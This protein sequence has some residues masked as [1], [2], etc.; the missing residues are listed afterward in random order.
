MSV[1]KNEGLEF[2]NVNFTYKPYTP[3]IQVLPQFKG[4]YGGDFRDARGLICNGDFS[5]A[6]VGN[7][8]K[9]YEVMNKNY[10]NIFN[11]EVQTMDKNHRLDMISGGI[12]AAATSVDA[13][14]R[15]TFITRN[16]R[17]GVTTGILTGAAAVA[18]VAIGNSKY[19][20]SKNAMID[21]FDLQLGNIKAR[22]DSL[23]NI[24][25]YNINNKYFPFIEIY[26][27]T[28][29]EKEALRLKLK[30]EG[31]TVNTI[32]KMSDFVNATADLNF[33]KAQL[34]RNENIAVDFQI[35]DAIGVELERGIYL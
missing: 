13:A 29:E 28:D 3:F 16:V 34:I 6:T 25:A 4:L 2:I 35:L 12:N 20:N 21:I 14:L 15:G 33:F 32:A 17:I 7:A 5:I 8:W 22:P 26:S 19:Q 30:Y 10:Q 11:T 27:A 24:S 23:K 18:D 31:M 9:E 1:A